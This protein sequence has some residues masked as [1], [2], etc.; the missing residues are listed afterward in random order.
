[1]TQC[2]GY[3]GELCCTEVLIYLQWTSVGM[4]DGPSQSIEQ[5]RL[6]YTRGNNMNRKKSTTQR[7][8]RLEKAKLKRQE[9][10]D[11][12]IF[13][14]THTHF[15]VH[16]IFHG[17]ATVRFDETLKLAIEINIRGTKEMFLLAKSCTKLRAFIQVSTAYSNCVRSQIGEIF[18][19]A[20][21]PADKVID[22][23]DILDD[24]LLE[25]FKKD[26]VGEHPNTY[27]YSKALAEDAVRQYSKDLPVAVVRPSIDLQRFKIA[28]QPFSLT[29]ML[30]QTR[31]L[32]SVIS[33]ASEPVTGWIDNFYGPT[34]IVVSAK[35]GLLHSLHCDP[36]KKADL[37]PGDYVVNVII[38]AAWRTARE[39]SGNGEDAP[40]DPA[41]PIY[42]VVSSVDNPLTWRSYTDFAELYGLSCPSVQAI[43]CYAFYLIPNKWLNMFLCFLMH[44]IPAYIVDGALLLVGKKPIKKSAVS[45]SCPAAFIPSSVIHRIAGLKP[46]LYIDSYALGENQMLLSYSRIQAPLRTALKSKEIPHEEQRQTNYNEF[47][48]GKISKQR[49]FSRGIEQLAEILGSVQKPR[50][51]QSGELSILSDVPADWLLFKGCSLTLL[52]DVKE[53]PYVGNFYKNLNILAV[54]VL[55]AISIL[56]QLKRMGPLEDEN[57]IENYLGKLI[58]HCVTRWNDYNLLIEDRAESKLDKLAQFL[59]K[60]H[61]Q[62][63]RHSSGMPTMERCS[64]VTTLKRHPNQNTKNYGRTVAYTTTEEKRKNPSLCCSQY[65]TRQSAARSFKKLMSMRDGNGPSK[66]ARVSNVYRKDIDAVHARGS[67][68]PDVP[69][70]RWKLIKELQNDLTYFWSSP[71]LAHCIQD[72]NAIR[73]ENEYPEAAKAIVTC[74]HMDD[75]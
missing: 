35:L 31:R 27:A 58:P 64:R 5:R 26:L 9:N 17:A 41:P 54:N 29:L 6:F 16:V 57:L 4:D 30:T 22:L 13:R 50:P 38:A 56:K 51:C 69:V 63:V 2:Q 49:N 45:T 65:D 52:K 33:T 74:T 43:W 67:T 25:K 1:M 11:N 72:I 47:E 62:A 48:E 40:S 7:K 36:K 46:K 32:F 15:Q 37:V 19:D 73:Y 12:K 59:M 10:I 14:Y 66:L 39:Y 68:Y 61:S 42:N 60:E 3:Q 71:F 28:Y 75:Y 18:Y 53:Q 21:L 23:V 70:A 24:E 8:R 55:N 44:W 20:P 34:G